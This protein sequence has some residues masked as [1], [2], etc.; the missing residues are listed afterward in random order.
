MSIN[1]QSHIYFRRGHAQSV[2]EVLP[3]MLST[4]MLR[5]YHVN[6][7][8]GWVSCNNKKKNNN[9]NFLYSFQVTSGL[10]FER[11]VP[12]ENQKYIIANLTLTKQP[13]GGTLMNCDAQLMQNLDFKI[14]VR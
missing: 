11:F 2:L 6:F 12:I 5:I 13:N 1:F 10:I 7:M 8:F 4:L 14:F 3:K 9:N